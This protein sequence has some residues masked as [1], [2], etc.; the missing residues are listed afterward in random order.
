M[1]DRTF[2]LRISASANKGMLDV[3]VWATGCWIDPYI[4]INPLAL[5]E[6][7]KYLPNFGVHLDNARS[8]AFS[9]IEIEKH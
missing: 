2:D 6:L 5:A 3:S 1:P 9:L 7:E 8:A 4:T